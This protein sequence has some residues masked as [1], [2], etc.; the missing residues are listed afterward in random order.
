ME[1]D[2]T[3]FAITGDMFEFSASQ[4]ERGM[5]AGPE[6]WANAKQEAHTTQL[7]TDLDGFRDYVADFGA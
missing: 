4:A 6:T 5:N 2:I 3:D 7:L 1:I